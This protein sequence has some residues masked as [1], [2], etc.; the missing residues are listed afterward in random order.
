MRIIKCREQ[1]CQAEIVFLVSRKTNKP[2]P[3]DA[4]SLSEMDVSEMN[5]T[6]HAVGYD[7]ER[8]VSHFKTCKKPQQFSGQ[9]R[10]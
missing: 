1:T 2:I 6:G 3:V 4:D 5:A 10:K 7:P 8:H 9:G